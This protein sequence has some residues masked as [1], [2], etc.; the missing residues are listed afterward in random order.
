M[1]TASGGPEPDQLPDLSEDHKNYGID[2]D[3]HSGDDDKK[4]VDDALALR[5]FFIGRHGCYPQLSGEL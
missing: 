5:D 4:H 1:A 2:H 3:N